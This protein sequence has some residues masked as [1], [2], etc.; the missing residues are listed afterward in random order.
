M[1]TITTVPSQISTVPARSLWI[2]RIRVVLTVLVIFH[3]AAITYGAS[4][5]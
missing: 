1:T 5:R 4:L 3:H 2:D